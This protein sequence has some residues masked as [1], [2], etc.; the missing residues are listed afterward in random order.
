[1]DDRIIL[2]AASNYNQKFYFNEEF[3]Q[4][5]EEVQNTLKVICVSHTTDVGGVITI[6]FNE[7]DGRL[8]IEASADEE[9]ILYD[10]IGSHL[11][12][13]E[14]MRL[15]QELFEGLET[16]FRVFYLGEDY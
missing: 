4:L 11:K 6:F 9:D 13:K 16:F 2:A 15:H 1:M 7:E 5:P 14:I 10:E 12:V 3:E 8:I